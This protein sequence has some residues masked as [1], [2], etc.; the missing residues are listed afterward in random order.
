MAQAQSCYGEALNDFL[1]EI[2]AETHRHAY[3]EYL[4]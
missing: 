1:D 3:S 2:L 4:V